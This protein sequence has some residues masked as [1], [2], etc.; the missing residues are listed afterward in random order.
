M[1][2]FR[3]WSMWTSFTWVLV[4]KTHFMDHFMSGAS[5][6]EVRCVGIWL[7]RQSL[8]AEIKGEPHKRRRTRSGRFYECDGWTVTVSLNDWTRNVDFTFFYWYT[9][10]T[11]GCYIFSQDVI[12]Y[13]IRKEKD[14]LL[15]H[16]NSGKRLYFVMYGW[17]VYY[18]NCMHYYHNYIGNRLAA[19]RPL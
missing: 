9:K 11:K 7:S 12:L 8:L 18:F 13:G 2:W 16:M 6:Y 15:F 14:E 5:S 10:N 1:K 19:P 4:H 17:V 3:I